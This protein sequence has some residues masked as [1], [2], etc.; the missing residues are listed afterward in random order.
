MTSDRRVRT[1]RSPIRSALA[2]YPPQ[3]TVITVTVHDSDVLELRLFKD[4][5]KVDCFNNPLSYFAKAS[6]KEMDAT[7]ERPAVSKILGATV[8]VVRSQSHGGGMAE[9]AV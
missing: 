2:R 3:R 6:K 9:S 5:A 4:G 1:S 8:D 7:T